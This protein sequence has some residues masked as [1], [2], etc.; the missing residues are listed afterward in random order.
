M[1]TPSSFGFLG[2][3]P[4][5]PFSWLSVAAVAVSLL[6]CSTESPTK[7]EKTGPI[8]SSSGVLSL[9]DG[10]ILGF[11]NP[12]SWSSRGQHAS[13]A[14]H[15][16]GAAALSV[17]STGWTEIT[18]AA[19]GSGS[20]L[21]RKVAVDVKLDSA[22]T[23]GGVSL[24]LE[25]PDSQIAWTR[26]HACSST[27]GDEPTC[28]AEEHKLAGSP[29]G[30]WL[31]LPFEFELTDEELAKLKKADDV[32]VRLVVNA[33]RGIRT[34][35]ALTFGS[36]VAVQAG[37][38]GAASN[39]A[40]LGF[41][42]LQDLDCEGS[43]ELS[44]D[45][46]NGDHALAVRV[47]AT[48]GATGNAAFTTADIVSTGPVAETLS[49]H[50][51][52]PLLDPASSEGKL[53]LFVSSASRG[54][55][56]ELVGNKTFDDQAFRGV[57]RRLQ[58]RL[59]AQLVDDLNATSFDD[60]RF[61]VALSGAPAGTYL[62]DDLSLVDAL[63]PIAS[64]APS[65]AADAVLGF[66][67]LAA[68]STSSGQIVLGD[69]V[70]VL[71]GAPTGE[72]HSIGVLGAPAFQLTSRSL[73]D[74]GELGDGGSVRL[75]IWLPA[76]T[77]PV[78]VTLKLD[79]PSKK[80][81]ARVVGTQTTEQG[82]GDFQELV[83]QLGSE[84]RAL[85]APDYDDLRV[86]LNV[87]NPGVVPVYF[88][89]LD[90]GQASYQPDFAEPAAPRKAAA[91]G[92]PPPIK[93]HREF[94]A[95]LPTTKTWADVAHYMG[96]E[97]LNTGSFDDPFVKYRSG[98]PTD[99]YPLRIAGAK[100]F[101]PFHI[102]ALKADPGGTPWPTLTATGT[103]TAVQIIAVTQL[104]ELFVPSGKFIQ[105]NPG[106]Y[107]FSKVNFAT[108]STVKL[109]NTS[110]QIRVF[111]TSAANTMNAT[112]VASTPSKNNVFWLNPSASSA[113]T[114]TA[115]AAFG[116]FA[117][118]LTSF[119][120]TSTNT[121]TIS[122][123]PTTIITGAAAVTPANTSCTS[124]N[125]TIGCTNLDSDADGLS[126]CE[127][128][129]DLL[130]ST[131][132]AVFNGLKLQT[133]NYRAVDNPACRV[134]SAFAFNE[135]C[136]SRPITQAQ[137]V[138]GW[139]K[140]SNV[141]G[142]LPA[143][144]AS[145]CATRLLTALDYC[146]PFPAP[147]NGIYTSSVTDLKGAIRLDVSGRH[148]FAVR[149]DSP[150]QSLSIDSAR[151]DTPDE[152]NTAEC[153][154]Y[155]AGIH[156]FRL[157]F[158]AKGD[159][160]LL[161]KVL[162][163]FGGIADCVPTQVLPSTLLYKDSVDAALVSCDQSMS[164]CTDMCPCP[165]GQG[166]CTDND[167]CT[168]DICGFPTPTP[169]RPLTAVELDDSLACTID[170]C[171]PA[172]GVRHTPYP[173]GDLCTT[174]VCT[175]AG[176]SYQTPEDGN[177][178]TEFV[179]D[180]PRVGGG[181]VFHPE[182]FVPDSDL[183][184]I[185]SCDPVAGPVHL[186]AASAAGPCVD[187]AAS[188][189]SPTLGMVLA[190]KPAGT[191]CGTEKTCT[192][193]GQCVY[194]GVVPPVIPA[195]Q[196]TVSAADVI[197]RVTRTAGSCALQP[198]TSETLMKI[199]G[200]ALYE[201]GS[202][203]TAPLGQV[204]VTVVGH[205]EF[206]QATTRADG[207]FDLAIPGGG[208]NVVRFTRPGYVAVDR[209]LNGSWGDFVGV[210][211]VVMM[212]SQTIGT[213]NV[214]AAPQLLQGPS[215][216]D[217]AGNSLGDSSVF[218]SQNTVFK[219][220]RPGFPDYTVPGTPTLKIAP[221]TSGTNGMERMP[222]ALPPGTDY[223]HAF[224]ISLQEAEDLGGEV[225]LSPPAV[226]YFD[227]FRGTNDTLL[228]TPAPLDTAAANLG[229]TLDGMDT[230]TGGPADYDVGAKV[231]TFSYNRQTAAWERLNTGNIIRLKCTGSPAVVSVEGMGVVPLKTGELSKL[232]V[233]VNNGTRAC[234]DELWRSE[235]DHFSSKDLN[236]R[237]SP[238]HTTSVADTAAPDGNMGNSCQAHGSVINIEEASLG[239]SFDVP[240][241][242]QTLNYNSNAM[243]GDRSGKGIL[244][245][246]IFFK[247]F[248]IGDRWY[249]VQETSIDFFH[250]DPSG[251][252]SGGG[253]HH[254]WDGTADGARVYGTF[255]A[256][257]TAAKGW[258]FEIGNFMAMGTVGE[259]NVMA[260]R[261]HDA[262][263]RGL[264]GWTLSG[265]H[266]YDAAGGFLYRGDVGTTRNVNAGF[267]DPARDTGLD[268]PG[269]GDPR[270]AVLRDESVLL[271]AVTI[272]QR[273]LFRV[274][275]NGSKRFFYP[276][277][278]ITGFAIDP[279][280]ET[281]VI[282]NTASGANQILRVP[283]LKDWPP[284]PAMPTPL[285]VRDFG[286]IKLLGLALARN[287][288]AIVAL[289]SP[290]INFSANVHRLSGGG[291]S[292]P[293]FALSLYTAS[294][295]EVVLATSSLDESVVFAAFPAKS[296]L[297][298]PWVITRWSP[299]GGL[300]HLA[301]STAVTAPS[302]LPERDATSVALR[303]VKPLAEA[304]NGSVLFSS[305]GS[306][307]IWNVGADGKLQYFMG[308]DVE[309]GTEPTAGAASANGV[310]FGSHGF[311][312]TKGPS[313]D[314]WIATPYTPA[315]DSSHDFRILKVRGYAGSVS[316][317]EV[318]SEDGSE[319]YSFYLDGRHYQT[320]DART[321]V[322][323][324]QFNYDA[325][326]RL[327]ASFEEHGLVSLVVRTPTSANIVSPFGHQTL[328]TFDS[329]GYAKSIDRPGNAD[330]K[331]MHDAGGLLRTLTDENLGEHTYDFDSNGKLVSDTSPGTPP[332]VQT[333]AAGVTNGEGE[334]MRASYA[335]YSGGGERE[336]VYSDGSGATAT[337]SFEKTVTAKTDGSTTTLNWRWHGAMYQLRTVASTVTQLP[338][339]PVLEKS[340]G[341]QASR[342]G[343]TW[344]DLFSTNA[345]VTAVVTTKD[346]LSGAASVVARSAMGR[347]IT[348]ILDPRGRPSS[349]QAGDLQ[350]IQFSYD[351][352]GRVSTVT[353]QS[354][355]GDVETV[356][357]MA[358]YG[359]Q[360]TAGAGHLKSAA[361][362]GFTTTF[363][364]DP[365][366]R[367][368][369]STS[370]A[371]TL[372]LAY[373]PRGNLAS[374]K[375]QGNK[376]QTLGYTAVD[377]LQLYTPE[378][379]ASTSWAFDKARRLRSITYPASSGQVATISH[380]RDNASQPFPGRLRTLLEDNEGMVRTT[381]FAYGDEPGQL[382]KPAQVTQIVRSP[383]TLDLTWRGPLLV[384]ER[385]TSSSSTQVAYNWEPDAYFRPAYDTVQIAGATNAQAKYE[386]NLDGQVT[387]V[388]SN[389]Y[390]GATF[391]DNLTGPSVAFC[392]DG[393]AACDATGVN[394]H[395]LL[396]STTAGTVVDLLSY[397]EFGQLFEART[398]SG[399]LDLVK[400]TY[401]RATS[402]R[403]TRETMVLGTSTRDRFFTYTA[404]GQLASVSEE[405]VVSSV[406]QGT[407]LTTYQYD[408]AGNLLNTWLSPPE[409]A[410][411]PTT[412][413]PAC[414]SVYD[415]NDLLSSSNGV[416]YSYD[417]RG[418]R[419]GA[420]SSGG[421]WTYAYDLQGALDRVTG[422]SSLAI[423][424]SNDPIG[425]RVK[426]VSGG[427]TTQYVWSNA[428]RIEAMLDG[429]GA[430]K[431]RFL[432]GSRVNVP[433]LIVMPQP[434]GA[435]KT[436][437]V[438]TDHLGSP[439]LVVNVA[440]SADV[441][442]QAFY[443]PW[444]KVDTTRLRIYN[445][446]TTNTAAWPIPFGFAGGL[447]DGQ[448]GLVR[449]GARD[450]DPSVGRWTAKDPILFGGGQTNLYVYAANDPIN[451]VDPEGE[452]AWG[453]LGAT[454]GGAAGFAIG[455]GGGALA[456]AGVFSV[457]TAPAGAYL[458]AGVGASL[459][460][461][462]GEALG[463][464]LNSLVD[465]LSFNKREDRQIKHLADLLGIPRQRLSDE[466]HRIKKKAGLRGRATDLL[467]DGTV[468]DPVSGEPIGN[469]CDE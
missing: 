273:G 431:A 414:D 367:P 262:K 71:E 381:T 147:V 129:S 385:R 9:T 211:P 357:T 402:G 469:V 349:I 191:S 208:R 358:Y 393:D 209:E 315:G 421:T 354:T 30:Q 66:N 394:K 278:T 405:F 22:V 230:G 462:T 124:C 267:V 412:G 57:Y 80:L 264:G 322:V 249:T 178:C 55:Q 404:Q 377:L 463:R 113:I 433:D 296:G 436:Y 72:A 269:Y 157:F 161:M 146:D 100:K 60:L 187:L 443:D 291:L 411:N 88:D 135:S 70:H 300:V 101:H 155:A 193:Q 253:I 238:D 396:E 74:V 64:P 464:G 311:G 16:E 49:V 226:Y 275:T 325:T 15:T 177:P 14:D 148:C 305:S 105:L 84:K 298:K 37:G 54:I 438:V 415:V 458:G 141:G 257:G 185:D 372:T 457:G 387:G 137:T 176:I 323:V 143:P 359:V 229:K 360:D 379:G 324:R 435:P 365:F 13:S 89:A 361:A 183:C 162:H 39:T 460:Y 205:C 133:T 69:G 52:L 47:D 139:G 165:E 92:D 235:F 432:Y 94:V 279:R 181:Q 454:V 172:L 445:T 62:F 232:Q 465:L 403:L 204:V 420:T 338:G 439:T 314:L 154:D 467:D 219:I 19:L 295:S 452:S 340:E 168:T 426:R 116:T 106:D 160:P 63:P 5:R 408:A 216:T 268:S 43:C 320:K 447:F 199:S 425:R 41:E 28:D 2:R 434:S 345:S 126:N 115:G 136:V 224:D 112:M 292:K 48:D 222:A 451:F 125:N 248:Q 202:Q 308:S 206:G 33:P 153:H 453:A 448:T 91:V 386:Y 194:A 303:D 237:F 368:L 422:P 79:L 186:P 152:T 145:L 10:A 416:S 366:G 312:F 440:N 132:P 117:A 67:D 98:S 430:M 461:L 441:L 21:T 149:N 450:Y 68:W 170:S 277:E 27:A 261:S 310:S 228:G 227:N 374:V 95:I 282:G 76:K 276:N 247:P 304:D 225:T 121:H 188:T 213:V 245:P 429:A 107:Y 6:N 3:S 4:F 400:F 144:A 8:D 263:A 413:S 294:A 118:D 280:D 399:A 306:R 18:S 407:K 233:A 285:V 102:E 190:Y 1:Q 256:S 459:G 196:P 343:D 341:T 38:L 254:W 371:K 370:D 114:R 234:G 220:V 138:T 56:N 180:D 355:E 428:L 350:P 266:S 255:R 246:T 217:A 375:N 195:G 380:S 40:V 17:Y 87:T 150:C 130:E 61:R 50:V 104:A 288:D 58:F 351:A 35:D 23:W 389:N 446:P 468:I 65:P 53:E 252:S 390:S 334:K 182:F 34:L 77:P 270:L 120:A 169:H 210:A 171:D 73:S 46:L 212:A 348:S 158:G 44:S 45:S 200:Q 328:I 401:E 424:Y 97:P 283:A 335:R 363:T 330:V 423:D 418:A 198:A 223:T 395:G 159:K 93:V 289:A 410:C 319:I 327:L 82:V 449:F 353:R 83:F 251:F 332:S 85:E 274:E 373:D 301:G 243:F 128:S 337:A 456:G 192:A 163:C 90:F 29:R 99:V 123:R 201:A 26:A 36:L 299:D 316:F 297:N 127:E 364:R 42:T 406:S 336:V 409:V 398:K 333:L 250:S 86:T 339:T 122:S 347:T 24:L 317:R 244:S 214:A 242:H 32:R 313:G 156:D 376:T 309:S 281:I 293:L 362:D 240:G 342:A 110:G 344:T 383:F 134:C 189:C 25:S 352:Y 119:P 78:T 258:R 81:V 329:N 241:I 11:E 259:S 271:K 388:K 166:S 384:G 221:L 173:D 321:G 164:T 109:N 369:T 444:G 302:L 437:R 260:V 142:A 239:E 167:V 455:G 12:V 218:F 397:D 287:G 203:I 290:D 59:P 318:P 466:L 20:G 419:K 179:C 175:A 307:A 103:S 326:S 284:A 140:P 236:F 108:G 51:K 442:L 151:V 391:Q 96:A 427:T 382:G 286:A 392:F 7:S 231:P 417:A 31:H 111:M 378:S 207:T 215:Y 272:G 75:K 331:L 265:H 197:G 174:D 356:A 346:P 131:D 184:T